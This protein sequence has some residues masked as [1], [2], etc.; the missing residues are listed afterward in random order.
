M[1]VASIAFYFVF[2]HKPYIDP[3]AAQ[4]PCF[5][6]FVGMVDVRDIYGDVRENF[7]DPI[8]IPRL[9]SLPGRRDRLQKE[10]TVEDLPLLNLTGKDSRGY[11]S[12]EERRD[13]V[14]TSIVVL[15]LNDHTA[16]SAVKGRGNG[17]ASL[18]TDSEDDSNEGSGSDRSGLLPVDTRSLLRQVD[19][20]VR[21]RK[22]NLGSPSSN[23]S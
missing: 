5:Q 8:P 18:D 21:E 17:T 22:N 2:S 6:S 3:A 20:D 7:V 9:P 4:V 23:D 14:E 13:S 15:S 11:E 12:S 10:Q 1:L 16:H 19:T